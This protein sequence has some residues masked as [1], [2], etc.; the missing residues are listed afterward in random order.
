MIRQRTAWL[1][2]ALLVSAAAHAGPAEPGTEHHA[3]HEAV[4]L[5]IE[6]V[7]PLPPDPGN[8]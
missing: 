2:A 8:R 4:S 6:G 7:G 5:S 3:F 1:A